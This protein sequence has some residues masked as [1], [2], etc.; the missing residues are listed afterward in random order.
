MTQE[1]NYIPNFE[2]VDRSGGFYIKE[3][4]N[5][6]NTISKLTGASL[7]LLHFCKVYSNEDNSIILD[8]DNINHIIKPILNISI[9]SIRKG[10]IQLVQESILIKL[11]SSIYLLN[12]EMF[13]KSDND[14]RN[15]VLDLISS[16]EELKIYILNNI[17]DNNK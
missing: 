9:S 17:F 1:K 8:K 3:Y 14:S 4:G 10:I 7:K 15:K 2:S 12:P 11:N 13:W 6:I 5:N 16:M